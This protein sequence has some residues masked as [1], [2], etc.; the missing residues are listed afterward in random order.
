MKERVH[1]M[2][3]QARFFGPL[4]AIDPGEPAFP[5]DGAPFFWLLDLAALAAVGGLWAWWFVGLL[6][7]RPL[8]PPPD[9]F[10]PAEATE[11]A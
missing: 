3:G 1:D 9:P 11:H 4:P 6:R 7:R 2:G 10:C 5:H 8:L